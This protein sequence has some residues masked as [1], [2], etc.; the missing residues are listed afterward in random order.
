[1]FKR[2]VFLLLALLAVSACTDDKAATAATATA[3]ATA[4]PAAA[5]APA[6][7]WQLGTDY[8][9]IDPRVPTTTGDKVEVVE[10]FSYA[11]PH[12]AHFQST[13]DELKAKLPATAQ[14]VL[15]PAVFN[16]Q[17]EPFAR[18]FY[19][20]R[21]LGVLD[22]THAALFEALH[23]QHRPLYSIDSLANDFYVSYGVD[24]KNFLGTADSFVVDSQIANGNDLVKRWGVSSTPTLVINGK[25]RIEMSSEKKI[26]PNE[27]L[28][29]ALMLVKQE[30]AA[31]K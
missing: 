10:V 26:G 29:I 31:K 2:L 19:T 1:M 11:C 9:L 3:S 15:V 14:I 22:K 23:T 4:K 27:A 24:P 5:A 13:M 17:W 16:P 28:E 30:A 7:D 8:S 20:A 6:R 21:S 25:Y 12:C 18:A